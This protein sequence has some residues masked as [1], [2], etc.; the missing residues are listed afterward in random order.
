MWKIRN[1]RLLF[2]SQNGRK[3][4]PDIFFSPSFY[5][6][7]TLVNH[8]FNGELFFK[9]K[10]QFQ[11]C[12]RGQGSVKAYCRIIG[13]RTGFYMYSHLHHAPVRRSSLLIYANRP[14]TLVSGGVQYAPCNLTHLYMYF[15]CILHRSFS[16]IKFLLCVWPALLLMW[17][18]FLW[19]QTI[20][21]LASF[22]AKK[23]R[24][25][26]DKKNVKSRHFEMFSV[27]PALGN[28]DKFPLPLDKDYFCKIF[29]RN[30]FAWHL[31]P[32]MQIWS[33]LVKD[34]KSQG[35]K[36]NNNKYFCY[37]MF[38]T[39]FERMRDLMNLMESVK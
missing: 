26:L 28:S 1:F 9:L 29:C 25:L 2:A 6:V 22:F 24:C 12:A 4:A 13:K 23:E 19:P 5:L 14:E 32:L 33:N 36:I 30:S 7:F 20:I 8:H 27:W 39:K 37:I 35:L 34:A 17:T 3:I 11:Y 31:Q 18:N 10:Q 16:K 21:F 15:N 38:W